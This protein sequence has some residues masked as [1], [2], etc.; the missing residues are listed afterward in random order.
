MRCEHEK[1][2]VL[3]KM[4]TVRKLRNSSKMRIL[5]GDEDADRLMCLACLL[6]KQGINQ[7]NFIIKQLS[8]DN[9]DEFLGIS[10]FN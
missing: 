2:I 3:F 7:N 8:K 1:K 4:Y 10:D 6:L 9:T 5:I